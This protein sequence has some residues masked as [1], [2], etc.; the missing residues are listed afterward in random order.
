VIYVWWDALTNYLTALGVDRPGHD[1]QY[2]WAGDGERV[3]V[4]GKGITRF[5]AVYWIG[6]LLSAGLPLPTTIHV[7]DYV[8][9]GGVKLS[10]STGNIVDPV[11]LVD[12]YGADALRWWLTRE[13]PLLGDTEFSEARLVQAYNTD[14]ANGLGNLASR[15]ATL[16]HKHYDGRL[17]L[18]D[19]PVIGPNWDSRALDAATAALPSSIDAALGTA[20][21][22]A[23]TAQLVA[24]VNSA[25]QLLNAAEPWK[26][27]K[28]P[29]I[30]ARLPHRLLTQVIQSCRTVTHELAPFCPAGAGRLADGPTGG[31]FPRIV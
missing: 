14:L 5:H 3:H 9:V 28:D 24:T 8:N 22:R 19:A 1:Y 26:L 6:L 12:A 17:L 2:W 10:K 23:A 7:H 30:D 31:P 21:F 25:N 27:L 15:T 18:D 20:D 4:I 29:T 13:V 11:E 16:L